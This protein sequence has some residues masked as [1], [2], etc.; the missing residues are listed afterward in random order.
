M[1]IQLCD[2]CGKQTKNCAAFLLPVED[3]LSS[4]YSYSCN[5]TRFG[6]DTVTLC[7]DCLED[8]RKFRYEHP[9]Y[10]RDLE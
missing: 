10:N 7:N 5:G 6:R 1:W 9:R 2:R 3:Q 8:F 4:D